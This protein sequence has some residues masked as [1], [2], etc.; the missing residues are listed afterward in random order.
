[1][2][3]LPQLDIEQVWEQFTRCR[4]VASRNIL[5]EHYLP[6]VKYSA[7]RLYVRFP[8]SVALDDLHSAGI[9]GL[10]DAI[11]KFDS[12]RNVK[13]ETYG[14]RRIEGTIW[15]YIRKTD[16]VPRFVR[17]QA[18]RLQAVRQRLES[19][20]GRSPTDKEMADELGM[21]M[22]RFCDYRQDAS[23]LGLVSLNAALTDEGEGVMGIDMIADQ[24]SQSPLAKAH[25]RDIQAL[26][27]KG[28]SRQEQLVI[29][30]YYYEQMT[31]KEIGKTLGISESRVCQLHSDILTRLRGQLN[32]VSFYE[33]V[34][35]TPS[36]F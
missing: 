15:D 4:D 14:V 7:E 18:K 27:K 6:L 30:L 24:K 12:A 22:D 16:W 28:L 13:F 8:K 25:Q 1:M 2:G 29:I 3:S 26:V 36:A 35:Q 5:I 21:D 31:M 32:K 11:E 17:A 34:C 9:L 33:S 20:F 23:A 19:L 10:M